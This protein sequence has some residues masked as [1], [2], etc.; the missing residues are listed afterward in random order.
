MKTVLKNASIGNFPAKSN[1]L[2][3]DDSEEIK[4]LLFLRFIVTFQKMSK[5]TE[6]VHDIKW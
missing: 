5:I 3:M 6:D 1:N 2:L 4:S